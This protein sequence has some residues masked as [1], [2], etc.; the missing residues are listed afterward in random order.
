MT[1]ELFQAGQSEISKWKSIG[2]GA[3]VNKAVQTGQKL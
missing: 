3:V 1:A 2:F